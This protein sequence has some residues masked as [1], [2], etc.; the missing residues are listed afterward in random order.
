M[1]NLEEESRDLDPAAVRS[2]QRVVAG[3]NEAIAE[4]QAAVRELTTVL[5]A[6]VEVSG[7]HSEAMERL[8][9][10][11]G[12]LTPVDGIAAFGDDGIGRDDEDAAD[13]ETHAEPNGG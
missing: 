5:G 1:A 11:T 10:I 2:L 4:L 13:D 12:R 7:V 3:H 6:Q 8:M 9:D